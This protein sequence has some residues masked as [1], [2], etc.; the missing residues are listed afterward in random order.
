MAESL[1]R[2]ES[3]RKTLTSDIAHELRTPLNNISGYL[4]AVADGVVEP[5]ERPIAS[6]QE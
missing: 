3:L 1:D 4:D 5:D 2:N 6:L